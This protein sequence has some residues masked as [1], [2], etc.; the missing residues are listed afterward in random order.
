MVCLIKIYN[1]L[2]LLQLQNTIGEKFYNAI[3][4][5]EICIVKQNKV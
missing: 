4:I 3:K 1:F 5:I 2:D